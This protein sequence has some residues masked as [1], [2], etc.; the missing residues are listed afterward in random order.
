MHARRLT[1]YHGFSYV[2]PHRYFVT[3]CTFDRTPLFTDE[4]IVAATYL[5][6]R[7]TVDHPAFA[8]LAYVFMP[9]HLHL[10]IGGCHPASDLR[11]C[12]KRFKQLSGHGFQQ[13]YRRRLWQDSYYDHVLRSSESTVS[14]ARYI[15]ENPVRNGLVRSPTDYPYLGS[16]MG[17][18][19]D[20]FRQDTLEGV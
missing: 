13:R 18:I 19:A 16:D 1:R 10:L 12:V 3:C 15:F 4:L 2:G 9:D 7:R 6:L 14:V 17:P 8:I 11:Q 5:Q 20:F